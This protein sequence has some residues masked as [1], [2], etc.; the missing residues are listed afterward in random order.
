MES[1][2]EI[3]PTGPKF[4]LRGLGPI[5]ECLC[6]SELFNVMCQFEDGEISMYL[7]EAACVI[8]GS[9]VTVPT[10]IDED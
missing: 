10:P 3:E 4:D 7:L 1:W 2:L 6:G 9:S 8:C 5:H